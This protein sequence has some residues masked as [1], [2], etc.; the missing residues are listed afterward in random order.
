M[1]F[2]P[3]AFRRHTRGRLARKSNYIRRK[4]AQ[5]KSQKAFLYELVNIV[6][7]LQEPAFVTVSVYNVYGQEVALLYNGWQGAGAQSCSWG[8]RRNGSAFAAGFYT[9]KLMINDA[10]YTGKLVLKGKN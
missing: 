1:R 8:G 5:E 6:Y 2:F 9:Y 3:S 10:A 7:D 4:K